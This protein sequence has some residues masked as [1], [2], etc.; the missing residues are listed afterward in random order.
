MANQCTC[1]G[2]HDGTVAKVILSRGSD[3]SANGPFDNGTR[4]I[5]VLAPVVLSVDNA[6]QRINLYPVHSTVI[7][8]LN[9]WALNYDQAPL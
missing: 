9:N 3:N 7:H 1:S 4:G 8:H 5:I 2:C 6:I